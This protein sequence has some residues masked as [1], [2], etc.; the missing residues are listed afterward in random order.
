MVRRLAT[1]VLVVAVLI[2]GVTVC[3]RGGSCLA[4]SQQKSHKCCH[5]KAAVRA[6]DCC[7]GGMKLGTRA[8]GT[9]R[10]YDGTAESLAVAVDVPLP[11]DWGV[12]GQQRTWLPPG[13]TRG[14]APPGTLTGQHTSL[15]L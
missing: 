14:L 11:G 9:E 2:A 7:S 3:P 8:L 4:M 1:V 15:L 13:I 10:G 12:C 5:S 6:E